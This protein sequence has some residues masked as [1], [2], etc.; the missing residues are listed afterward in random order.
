[1]GYSVVEEKAEYACYKFSRQNTRKEVMLYK[2]WMLSSRSPD[3]Y[4]VPRKDA[5]PK[6]SVE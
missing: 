6:P 4:L 5:V 3:I 2:E 1:M